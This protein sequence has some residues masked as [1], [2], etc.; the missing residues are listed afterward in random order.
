MQS[1]SRL[2]R[3]Y[4]I[5]RAISRSPSSATWE[6]HPRKSLT[7]R[8]IF[9]Q[10]PLRSLTAEAQTA[11]AQRAEA[12][13]G[14]QH[15]GVPDAVDALVEN[16]S[17]VF[18]TEALEG[19]TLAALLAQGRRFHQAEIRHFAAEIGSL[20]LALHAHSDGAMHGAIEPRHLL[21]AGDQTL[22]L[23]DFQLP[24]APHAE[25]ADD[26]RQ[27]GHTLI[28]LLTHRQPHE[29]LQTPRGPLY[30]HLVDPALSRLLERLVNPR[31]P[32]PIRRAEELLQALEALPDRPLRRPPAIVLG[33]LLSLS[34]GLSGWLSLRERLADQLPDGRSLPA[35][36]ALARAN[37][38]YDAGH[39]RTALA[40]FQAGRPLARAEDWYRQGVCQQQTGAYA[41]AIASLSQARTREAGIHPGFLAYRLGYA[42]LKLGDS[43]AAIDYLEQSLRQNPRQV[44]V[45]NDL[46]LAQ[47]QQQNYPAALQA[48]DRALAIR[49]DYPYAHANRG[50]TL[51]LLGQDTDAIQAENRALA[52]EPR[53][54]L[55]HYLKAELAFDRQRYADC[56]SETLAATSVAPRYSSAQNLR[57]LCLHKLNRNPEAIQAFQQALDD[58]P[59]NEVAWFNLGLVFDEQLDLGQALTAYTH[60]IELNPHYARALNNL[61]YV[62]ERRNQP[63]A[64]LSLYQRAIQ[65]DPQGLYFA[66][67]AGLYRDLQLCQPSRDDAR[68]ACQLGETEACKWTCP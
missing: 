43:E 2:K 8:L 19:E 15:P 4:R 42:S 60:A 40:Y 34:L 17:L 35:G 13:L 1:E 16:G 36:V 11:A 7:P 47:M 33:L 48:F 63:Q 30:Q 65:A 68:H 41:Q 54:A 24:L 58:N 32:A 25:P 49:P 18:V 56:L 52:L 6:G 53:Y 29:L 9:K 28:T 23:I 66:N 51:H 3:R 10:W 5:V 59:A 45:L 20:L 37:Q 12:L 27:L 50:Q 44:G 46:G 26:L 31:H 64:A 39:C 21:L 61:G 62:Y 22:K 67:R 38:A 57:G 14:F 55:P